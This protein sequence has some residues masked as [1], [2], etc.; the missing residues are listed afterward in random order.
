ML[1]KLLIAIGIII[2]LGLGFFFYL[3]ASNENPAS[4]Y[5]VAKYDGSALDITVNYCQPYKKGRLIFGEEKDGALQPYGKKWRTGANEAT[6]I[7]F[8]T[9]VMIAGNML[10]KGRYSLYTIPGQDKW[11]VAFNSKVDY[12]GAFPFMDPF[13]ESKDVLRVEVPVMNTIDVTE[14]FKI[15]FDEIMNNN[16][17]MVLKWDQTQV[18]IPI[19]QL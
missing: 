19:S 8:T 14:Q 5:D 3:G 13:D 6:E 18:N 15:T 12:W 9:D 17:M 1:K 4:P 11:T 16:V 10:K 2:V 7:E